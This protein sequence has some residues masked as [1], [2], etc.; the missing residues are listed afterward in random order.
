MTM[1]SPPITEELKAEAKRSLNGY[2]YVLDGKY[3]NSEEIPATAILGAWKVNM[4]GI[5]EGAFIPNPNYRN[6]TN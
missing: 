5:I 6:H 1:P 4:H 3:S 2:V